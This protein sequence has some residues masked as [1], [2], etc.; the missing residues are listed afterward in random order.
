MWP[1]KWGCR[2]MGPLRE[3]VLRNVEVLPGTEYLIIDVQ[4]MRKTHIGVILTGD[5]IL[6]AL[7]QK[8]KENIGRPLAEIAELEIN[9]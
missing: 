4:C 1:P 8:L 5:E 2:S 6:H 3:G 7:F 9:V